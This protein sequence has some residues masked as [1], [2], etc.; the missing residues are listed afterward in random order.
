MTDEALK[1]IINHHTREAGVRNLERRVADVC[2]GVAV[3]V[4]DALEEDR[5][6]EKITVDAE[7]VGDYLGPPRYQY[8]VAERTATIMAR[9]V[10]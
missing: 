2:R 1:T 8:E 6:L 3:K 7:D 5:V 10:D 9:V 4:A